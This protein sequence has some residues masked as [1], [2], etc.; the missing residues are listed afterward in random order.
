MASNHDAP[1]QVDLK[2]LH[3]MIRNG[4]AQILDVRTTTEYSQGHIEG[5]HNIPYQ[6]LKDQVDDIIRNL[7]APVVL[8]SRSGK[9]A[10]Q[11]GELLR[12]AGMEEVYILEEGLK[13]YRR[14]EMPFPAG[15]DDDH[16]E[17]MS[18]LAR[19]VRMA[20]GAVALA[21]AVAGLVRRQNMA[22]LAGLAIGGLAM[23]AMANRQVMHRV[24]NSVPRNSA[25]FDLHRTIGQMSTG[26]DVSRY[27]I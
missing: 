10:W 18:S 3:R 1:K 12:K 23:A 24:M 11:A 16:M 26:R 4:E 13:P 8:V 5:S 19:N 14:A 27:T 15:S 9:R 21:G 2:D 20:S 17:R 6:H 25:H 7:D 22:L